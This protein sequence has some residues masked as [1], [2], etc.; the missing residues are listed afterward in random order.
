[1]HNS[2]RLTKGPVRCTLLMHPEDAAART[3]KNEEV[4]TV[5]STVG[6][7]QLPIEISEE[8]MPGVVS[9]P[10]GWGHHRKGTRQK[11]AEENPGVSIND[12]TDPTLLDTLTGNA[13]FSNN[14]VNVTAV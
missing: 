12:L 3:L 9:I 1:M 10:H 2:H 11:N 6:A 8:I 7:V 14:R 5:T 13:A 4:V